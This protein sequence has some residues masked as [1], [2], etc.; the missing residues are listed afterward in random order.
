MKL[1]AL[2]LF[3]A[4]TV[5]TLPNDVKRCKINDNECLLTS[6]N[7]VLNQYWNGH[8]DLA[9]ESIDPFKVDTMTIQQNSGGVNILAKLTKF[10]IVGFSG[11]KIYKLSGFENDLIDLRFR[12]P[13]A[14]LLGPY[15]INGNILIL[16]VNGSGKMK[17][18]FKNFDIKMKLPIVKELKEGKVFMKIKQP[19]MTF[20]MTGGDVNLSH[21]GALANGFLNSNFNTI[22][23]I[24]K[25]AISKSL[26]EKLTH[27]INSVFSTM[28]YDE[29]F[30]A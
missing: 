28:S 7:Y 18:H 27:R 19:E 2:F 22:I 20:D 30:A 4:S 3:F 15:K 25:P 21:L 13:A 24:I 14:T 23:N 16:P 12:M 5:Y 6:A 10:D 9:L 17:L 29:L 26:A 1:F 11:A 8:P